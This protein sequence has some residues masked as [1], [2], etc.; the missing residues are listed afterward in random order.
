M[1]TTCHRRRHLRGVIILPQLLKS[2]S[3]SAEDDAMVRKSTAMKERWGNRTEPTSLRSS[4]KTE[5]ATKAER[6]RN[7]P[8]ETALSDI[9]RNCP[10]CHT[11]RAGDRVPWP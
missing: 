2:L 6:L 11:G 10:D 7:E 5:F 1:P 3:V 9:Y 4:F 8:T